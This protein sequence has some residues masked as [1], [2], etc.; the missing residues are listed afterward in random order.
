MLT[1]S[2]DDGHPADMRI[3]D[4]MLK[5]GI[6]GTFYLPLVNRDGL[7]V[8]SRASMR[9]LSLLHEIGSHTYSHC[10]LNR[11]SEGEA[12]TEISKG[13]AALE[14]A[15]GQA[16]AGF[17]YPGGKYRRCHVSMVRRAGFTYARGIA[18]CRTDLSFDRFRMP[19]TLQIYP[20]QRSIYLRN[21]LSQG[22]W[23]WRAAATLRLM[24][25]RALSARV[26]DCLEI[27]RPQVG[28]TVVHL[29]GHSW[30]LDA[31]GGWKTLAEL[32][33]YVSDH[34]GIALLRN[35]DVAAAAGS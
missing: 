19:T 24:R 4:L 9:E 5:H 13:K 6:R 18:S 34:P 14:D 3:A 23:R 21:F 17:S 26:I 32:F 2:W 30:E 10:Y 27:A 29:W 7:P 1:M 25:G 22:G 11:V 33:R 20:H 15:L 31:I 16:I 35:C 8:M 12:A 28:P